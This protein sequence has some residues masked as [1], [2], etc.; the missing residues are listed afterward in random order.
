MKNTK[1]GRMRIMHTIALGSLLLLAPTAQ[2]KNRGPK[3]A[4]DTKIAIA[5]DEPMSQNAQK[6]A[7]DEIKTQ[8]LSTRGT[9]SA[10]LR[11]GTVTATPEAVGVHTSLPDAVTHQPAPPPEAAALP[12]VS[13]TDDAIVE[14]AAKPMRH[15]RRSL[16]ACAADAQARNPS[17]K[18]SVTLR[19]SVEDRKVVNV[20]VDRDSLHDAQLTSCL[21]SAGHALKFTLKQATFYWPV[22]L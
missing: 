16:D 15:E 3:K 18:G 8:A 4:A 22:S 7:D 9:D 13:L 12:P 20:A 19:F 1:M 17:A 14:L 5:D 6:P 11:A 10:Q 21:V 2:A